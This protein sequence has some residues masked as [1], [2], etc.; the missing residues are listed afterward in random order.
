[1]SPY[2]SRLA[3]TDRQKAENFSFML[4]EKNSLASVPFCDTSRKPLRGDIFITLCHNGLSRPSGWYLSS[5]TCSHKKTVRYHPDGAY[6]ISFVHMLQRFSSSGASTRFATTT[7]L[8]DVT[9]ITLVV[10]HSFQF[11]SEFI[12]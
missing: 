10:R 11:N 9:K 8:F 12:S 2:G 7:S 6:S 5:I 4:S 3:H 1:M